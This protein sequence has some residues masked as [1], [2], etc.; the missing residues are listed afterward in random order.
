MVKNELA[1]EG[2][3][4]DLPWV[5]PAATSSLIHV[6]SVMQ[7]LEVAVSVATKK[8]G[9]SSSWFISSDHKFRTWYYLLLITLAI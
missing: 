9:N 1:P 3:N 6:S 8:K 7:P 2:A 5:E 4:G